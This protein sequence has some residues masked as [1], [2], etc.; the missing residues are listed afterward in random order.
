MI[1]RNLSIFF[2]IELYQYSTDTQRYSRLQPPLQITN[3]TMTFLPHFMDKFKDDLSETEWSEWKQKW[4]KK[5]TLWGIS[6]YYRN[7]FTRGYDF[8]KIIQNNQSFPYETKTIIPYFKGN[9][10]DTDQFGWGFPIYQI[11]DT[12]LGCMVLKY[13]PTVSELVDVVLVNPEFESD[14][15]NDQYNFLP[16]PKH[17]NIPF[18]ELK[19]ISKFIFGF[20]YQEKP[21]GYYWKM[22][23]SNIC[24]PTTDSKNA[25]ATSFECFQSYHQLPPFENHYFQDTMTQ[26]REIGNESSS[27]RQT[28]IET[29]N[30]SF[31]LSFLFFLLALLLILFY[32]RFFRFHRI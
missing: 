3:T 28:P 21:K 6:E 25:F 12:I 13:R 2:P 27:M 32:V 20:F 4:K 14:P 1:S 15:W 7:Y 9:P 26:L 16:F 10:I 30:I 5:G 19:W 24:I 31:S 22:N 29:T 18:Y 17:R 8:I 11:P 23:A